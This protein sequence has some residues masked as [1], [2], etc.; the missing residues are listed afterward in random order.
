MIELCPIKLFYGKISKGYW[1][2]VNKEGSRKQDISPIFIPSGRLF[3]Y[4]VDDH[5]LKIKKNISYI[6]QNHQMNVN[7]DTPGDVDRLHNIYK[8]NSKNINLLK[9]IICENCFY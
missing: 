4:K 3:I 6:I 8:L 2:S 5:F 1:K 7:I 9:I